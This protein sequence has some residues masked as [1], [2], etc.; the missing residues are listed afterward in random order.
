MTIGFKLGA[1]GLVGLGHI[2]FLCRNQMQENPCALDMAKEP[3]ADTDA[4]MRAFDQSR[5]IGNDEFARIDAG[6]AQ[7]RMQGGEGIIGDFRLGCRHAGKKCRLAGIRLAEKTG[8]GDQFQPQ[9]QIALFAFESR[10]SAARRLVGR[11]LEVQIAKAAI[12]ALGKTVALAHGGKIVDQ[13]FIVVF[14]NLRSHG[15]LE[16]HVGTLAARHV[17]AHAVHAGKIANAAG[18]AMIIASGTRMHPLGAIDA[19]E[20]STLFKPSLNPVNAWKTWISGNLEPAGR[21]VI[22]EGALT[23]LKSGKSLLAAGVRDVAGQFT[24]GDTVAVVG[25]DGREAARGLIAYDA[26]DA[27]RIAGRKTNEIAAILGYDARSAMIHRDDLVVRAAKRA[28][29]E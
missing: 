18:T 8:I 10:I 14:K 24:R 1:H 27:V 15:N 12:A 2:L 11:C 4:L 21:L 28:A 29:K 20:R 16:Y 7:I 25:P 17:A 19:G 13:G 23:A 26:A 22:D 5:N 9:P 6:N 3:V